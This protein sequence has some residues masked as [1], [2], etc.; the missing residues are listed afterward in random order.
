VNPYFMANLDIGHYVALGG[1]PIAFINKHHA[2]ITNLHLKDRTKAIAADTAKGIAAKPAG[3]LPFGQGETP[4][5]DVLRLLKKMKWNIPANIE[6]EYNGDPLV[7]VPK[8]IQYCK[9]ALL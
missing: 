5:K 1:D 4:I 3:N 7:E 8:C 2:R 6:F 9:D